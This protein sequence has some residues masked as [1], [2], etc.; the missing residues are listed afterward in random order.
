[1]NQGEGG[2]PPVKREL[3]PIQET[4][5]LVLSGLN[6]L[7]AEIEQGQIPF[8]ERDYFN[9]TLALERVKEAKERLAGILGRS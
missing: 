3:A 5:N 8:I 7:K 4:I 6:K 1:M 9:L 2:S